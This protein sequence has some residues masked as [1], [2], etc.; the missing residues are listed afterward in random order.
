[1]K[2]FIA[3]FLCLSLSYLGFAQITQR[4]GQLNS[5]NLAYKQNPTIPLGVLE[6]IA[7]SKTRL[8]YISTQTSDPGCTGLP[9]YEGVMGLIPDGKGYFKNTLDLVVAKSS[10]TKNDILSNRNSEILAY[11][12]AFSQIQSELGIK[13]NAIDANIAVLR[14]LSELPRQTDGQLFAQDAEIYQILKFLEDPAFMQSVNRVAQTI[15]Y[16]SI[17][18]QN[19][20]QILASKSLIFGKNGIT[21][22]QNK[23]YQPNQQLVCIDYP[24]AIWVAA[25]GSNYS[26]RG[27]TPVSAITIHTVQGSYAGAISWFQNPSANVSAHYVLRSSDGQVTQMVCESDKGWHVGTENPYTIGLEHEGFV[28]D[29]SWY[30]VAMYG[31]SADVCR[32]IVNSGYGIDPHRTAFWPWTATTYYNASGIPGSC[33][34]IKGHMHFPNQS[35]TDPGVN[36]NWD[37]FF[38]LIND[39]PPTTSITACSGNFTDSGG[40]VANYGD[41]ERNLTVIE[42]TNASSV[43][44]TFTS[45]NLEDTWD[46]MYIYDGNSIWAPLIGY[47]TGTTSPGSITSSG[48][49]LAVEFRSDCATT[50]AGWEATW[51]F[52]P[53]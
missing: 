25:D 45:F 50:A 9:M 36:W 30:T 21:N 47:Y 5:F 41:D 1:M 42:P 19:N 38:K 48:G 40:N 14:Y 2:K 33:T 10:Y 16:K 37:Y 4:L 51:T 32:D 3:L 24:G 46:Y 17:F 49:A 7:N 23:T 8:Q 52:L 29:P 11:A 6:A 44:L 18:G 15:S 39:P 53:Y 34:K 13:S 12:E 26:S 27:G 31:S 28:N 35:H 43:T 22:S 20:F